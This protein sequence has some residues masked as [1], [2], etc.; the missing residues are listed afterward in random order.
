MGQLSEKRILITAGPTQEP[1][2]PVRYI[3]NRSSGKM[4]LALAYSAISLGAEVKLILGP[5]AIKPETNNKLKIYDVVTAEEMLA[6]VKE[7]FK[8]AD[9]II[10]SAAVSDFKVS[11]QSL[12]KIKKSF[13]ED[14]MTLH[15]IKNPDI[16][17]WCSDNKQ[18]HQIVVGFA[19]ETDNALINAKKKIN[20]KGCDWLVLNTLENEKAGFALDTNHISILKKTGEV[21]NF[22]AKSKTD[23]AS[24]IF[25][26]ILNN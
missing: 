5:I 7:T 12:V 4:G 17:K 22:T 14:S 9:L 8:D 19:L 23:V 25:Q 11:E 16:L 10:M 1:I 26:T 24:D 13:E 6:K 18:F 15:L 3:S 21:F 2:D 20:R